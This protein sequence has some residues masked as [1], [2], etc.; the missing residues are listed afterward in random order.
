MKIKPGDLFWDKN[1]DWCD[2]AKD[3]DVCYLVLSAD[4]EGALYLYRCAFFMWACGSYS[5]AHDRFFTEDEVLKMEL[6]GNISDIKSFD[7]EKQC[8][9]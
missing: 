1:R 7:K 9:E 2:G 6:V 4:Q 8:K 5:G 3:L